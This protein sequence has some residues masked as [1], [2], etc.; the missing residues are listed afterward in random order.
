[1]HH[2]HTA[3][4][5]PLCTLVHIVYSV[6]FGSFV[7]IILSTFFKQIVHFVPIS[8]FMTQDWTACEFPRFICNPMIQYHYSVYC[9]KT[10]KHMKPTPVTMDAEC[11]LLCTLCT[12]PITFFQ[13]FSKCTEVHSLVRWWACAL[14]ESLWRSGLH[15]RALNL[16]QGI[17]SWLKITTRDFNL[18]LELKPSTVREIMLLP[19]LQFISL[20]NILECLD[21]QLTFGIPP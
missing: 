19:A 20:K 7:S 16:R 1:M 4:G 18:M 15:P 8:R 9:M 13:M 12:M 5:V 3:L 6:H 2:E 17:S 11:A 10:S 21:R 14:S